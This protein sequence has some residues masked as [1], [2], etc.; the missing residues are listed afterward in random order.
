MKTVDRISCSHLYEQNFT[1]IVPQ[2]T[3]R[4]TCG[5]IILQT[6]YNTVKKTPILSTIIGF[7]QT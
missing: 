1:R 7:F 4:G 3:L 5:I 6:Q 2:G